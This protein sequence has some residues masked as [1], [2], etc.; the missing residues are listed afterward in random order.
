M[1]RVLRVI[2]LLILVLVAIVLIN[3]FR[4]ESKTYES[5]I[6]ALKME[7]DPA[8]LGGA[9]RFETISHKTEMIDDSAFTGFH[10]YLSTSFPLVDSLLKKELFSYSIMYTWPGEDES[11]DPIVLM[12]HMDVVP[13]E[14]SSRDDWDV[15]AFSGQIYQ[16]HIYGRGAIDDKG[17]L[18]SILQ[19]TEELLKQNFQPKRTIVFCFGQDE[20]IGGEDGAL[21]MAKVLKDRGV[22]AWMVLDEGGTFATGLVPGLEDRRVAL[23]GTSEKGY[24]SLEFNVNLPGGHSSFPA[25]QTSIETLSAALQKLRNDPLPDKITPPL[26]GFI[27]HIGSELPFV[28]K[29][30]F[31]NRWLFK[32]MIFSAYKKSPTGAAMIH[33]T[34]V[35]TIFSSGI[36][37]NV[38]PGRARAVVNFRLLP[39]DSPEYVLERVRT[40]IGDTNVRI[41]IL[42]DLA[43]PA[44]PVSPYDSEQFKQLASVVQAI[45]KEALVSPY[46]VLNAT[47]A[48]H[49]Y[50]ISD[51]VYR[52]S[53]I[54]LDKSDIPRI[55]GVNE[56]VS[57]EAFKSSV[58]FYATLLKNF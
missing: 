22:K 49:F 30:A 11:L 50:L 27:E 9:L 58:N 23:I 5:S 21:R 53:P 40:T 43:I 24:L 1:R 52:F 7:A 51:H 15:P 31:A 29:M 13:V 6:E 3:T 47:D 48:R 18:I 36:K 4:I 38:I 44:S 28:Q 19:G 14:Y 56:R 57:I 25:S 39:G 54:P 45:D 37:D 34:Q 41:S 33:T 8:I 55:H 12:A 16:D 17:S 20:E 35:P 42:N 32:S 46:L 10:Q 2:G 26:E